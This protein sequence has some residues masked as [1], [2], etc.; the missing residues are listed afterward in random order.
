MAHVLIHG[1]P[2]LVRVNDVRTIFETYGPIYVDFN[3]S[4]TSAKIT[5]F[6]SDRSLVEFIGETKFVL[7]GK[8]LQISPIYWR[9]KD[10]SLF[11]HACV[12]YKSIRHQLCEADWFS[13]QLEILQTQVRLSEGE[14]QRR[15]RLLDYLN[16]HLQ[17][18]G[19]N[20]QLNYLGSTIN[21]IGFKDSDVD[22]YLS[23]DG[24]DGTFTKKDACDRLR[25]VLPSLNTILGINH[26]NIIRARVPIIQIYLSDMKGVENGLKMDICASNP[27]GVH[28]S[29]LIQHFCQI[30]PLFADL[31]LILKFWAKW[32]GILG[33]NE[34]SSYAF[35]N[36]AIFFCQTQGLL[37]SV[38]SMQSLSSPVMVEEK[39]RVDFSSEH[40][41]A[42][43]DKP[44]LYKLLI[45]FFEYYSSFEFNKFVICPFYGFP[46]GRKAIKNIDGSELLRC[47]SLICIQDAFIRN[48]NL[49]DYAGSCQVLKTA[50]DSIG[51]E[52]TVR[53][54]YYTEF[55][56][57]AIKLMLSHGKRDNQSR[58]YLPGQL[59]VKMGVTLESPSATLQSANKS[60]LILGPSSKAHRV[61]EITRLTPLFISRAKDVITTLLDLTFSCSLCNEVDAGE[62]IEQPVAM[63]S[64]TVSNAITDLWKSREFYKSKLP[65]HELA[66]LDFMQQEELISKH[67]RSMRSYTKVGCSS[68]CFEFVVL[69]NAKP[70]KPVVRMTFDLTE[71]TRE[72]SAFFNSYLMLH[73]NDCMTNSACNKENDTKIELITL[74]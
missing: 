53:K 25:S 21:G 4:R 5:F 28:N 9:I 3:E 34:M 24:F 8:A 11:S 39:Y 30:E 37:P 31:A 56:Q 63:F 10:H 52:F 58:R 2:E 72:F 1:L 68:Y 19:A 70:K 18:D 51:F 47:N 45:S 7:L 50:I 48:R 29:K 16:Q 73:F 14:V 13:D 12:Q 43:T 69:V 57:K 27:T 65:T 66:N 74:D 49:T 15:H 44:P 36:L 46:I 22:M 60:N 64:V 42:K 61:Q 35:I 54:A 6:E 41:T 20:G 17:F 59:P 62:C 38:E 67:V 32:L 71:E 55:S 33:S 40:F 23:T 26:H